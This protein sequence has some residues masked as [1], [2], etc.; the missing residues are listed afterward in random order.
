M[1][2][3]VG[4]AC[5]LKLKIK[6]IA[7]IFNLFLKKCFLLINSFPLIIYLFSL[8][9]VVQDVYKQQKELILLGE[10]LVLQTLSFDLELDNPYKSLFE[11]ISKLKMARTPLHQ[12]AW[13]Y[14]KD[15]YADN[16]IYYI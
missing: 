2:Q 16:L 4:P 15:G 14:V 5:M 9:D 12:V 8:Y 10:S 3:Q 11:A 13:N 7:F 1:L 6:F